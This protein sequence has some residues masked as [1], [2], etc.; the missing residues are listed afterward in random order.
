MAMRGAVVRGNRRKVI[1]LVCLG[2]VAAL[3]LFEMGVRLLPADAVQY[4]IQTSFN[5]GPVITRTATLTDPATVARWRAAMTAQPSG[6]SL[7]G[8]LIA[9]QRG[10]VM[11]S[12]SGGT[13]A[14]Y[15]FL[16]HGLPTESVSAL[17]TCIARYMIW[18][19]SIPD[20]GTYVIDPLV[21]P[22]KP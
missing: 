1:A 22:S 12:G 8:T 16:W 14:S 19:G 2:L 5:G 21:Q 9:Q 18:R 20:L 3:V 15:V 17:P 6:E 13:F 4:E 10:E 11:C 7:V